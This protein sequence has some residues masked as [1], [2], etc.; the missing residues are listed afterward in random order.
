MD[1]REDNV[2][3][4]NRVKR[5]RKRKPPDRDFVYDSQQDLDKI[6]RFEDSWKE[7]VK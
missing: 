3:T 1:T 6:L 5:E 2:C 7:Q 4:D